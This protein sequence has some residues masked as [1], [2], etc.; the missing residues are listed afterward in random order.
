MLSIFSHIEGIIDTWKRFTCKTRSKTAFTMCNKICFSGWRL[1]EALREPVIYL[2]C[3]SSSS[4]SLESTLISN[5]SLMPRRMSIRKAVKGIASFCAGQKY[6]PMKRSGA[7]I[8][9]PA[10]GPQR[11]LRHIG[12][13]GQN[14]W[15]HQPSIHEKWLIPSQIN[16]VS[17]IARPHNFSH[18]SRALC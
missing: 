5:E 7:D 8:L 10:Q 11:H 17:Q 9:Q 3:F 6:S 12:Q 1:S 13:P 16:V 14:W 15:H 18:R 2:S 4:Y